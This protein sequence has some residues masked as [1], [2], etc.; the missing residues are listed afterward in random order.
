MQSG[1]LSLPKDF[2]AKLSPA[3]HDGAKHLVITAASEQNLASVKLKESA[4]NRPDIDAEV[5]RH[6]EDWDECQK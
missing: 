5:I 2:M 4:P 3:F 6:A 1:E